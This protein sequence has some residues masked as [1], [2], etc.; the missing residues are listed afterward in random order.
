MINP[1]RSSDQHG[2]R[3]G[4]KATPGVSRSLVPT[5]GRLAKHRSRYQ[6]LKAVVRDYF[7]VRVRA[8]TALKEI[9][10]D[11]LYKE[12]YGTFEEFCQQECGMSRAQAYRQM[13]LPTMEKELKMSQIETKNFNENQARAIVSVPKARRAEVLERVV[14][15]GGPVTAKAIRDAGKS[16][17]KIIEA[18][19]VTKPPQP[20]AQLM[21]REDVDCTDPD[22]LPTAPR[23]IVTQPATFESLAPSKLIERHCPTCRCLLKENHVTTTNPR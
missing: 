3:L 14:S 12:E 22:Q 16:K 2:S 1:S 23:A 9:H 18:E 4:R 10:D 8:A 11:K 20:I 7:E 17:P 13:E 15:G 21:Q 5:R 19:I 6:E